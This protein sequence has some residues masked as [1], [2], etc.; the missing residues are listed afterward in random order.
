M[1]QAKKKNF[2]SLF[3]L[4]MLKFCCF[5]MMFSFA[6][7]HNASAYDVSDIRVGQGVG[8]IR[9]VFDASKKFE[10]NVFLLDGPKR[11]VVDI[12]GASVDPKIEKEVK[13]NGVFLPNTMS[14]KKQIVPPIL[15]AMK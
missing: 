12:K 8:S 5:I 14:R 1:N 9:I 2:L 10:Y 11:L 15:G 4:S 7:I 6:R 13:D 3:L